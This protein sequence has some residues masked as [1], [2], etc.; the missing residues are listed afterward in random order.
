MAKW[1]CSSCGYVYDEEV[2]DPDHGVKPGT[3]WERVPDDWEC[4]VC[5]AKKS[6]KY[7][8]EKIPDDLDEIPVGN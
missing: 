2:G 6:D 3:P 5:G 7:Y 8:W 4:P 1:L